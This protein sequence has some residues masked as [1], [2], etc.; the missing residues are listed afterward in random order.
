MCYGNVKFDESYFKGTYSYWIL[1]DG[2]IGYKMQV[3][4]NLYLDPSI[5]FSWKWEVKGRGDVDNK[6]INNLIY[7]YEILI[8][9]LPQVVDNV[10]TKYRQFF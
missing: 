1:I 7:R 8:I 2:N 10:H 5:G 9:S 3:V 6:D 4:K